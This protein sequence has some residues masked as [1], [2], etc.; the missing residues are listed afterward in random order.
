MYFIERSISNR[1]QKYFSGGSNLLMG[2][3][4]TLFGVKNTL[5]RGLFLMGVKN[6]LVWGLTCIHKCTC[7][8]ILNQVRSQQAPKNH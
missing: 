7:I 5:V 2:S 1:G 4:F 6:T 8:S 3:N